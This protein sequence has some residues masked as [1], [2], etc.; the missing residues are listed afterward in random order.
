MRALIYTL[1][2][3]GM[4]IGEALS[5]KVGDVNLKE[6]PASIAIK[7]EYSKTRAGRVAYISDEAKE[8]LEEIID[9]N[10]P[11]DRLVFDYSGDLWQKG[12]GSDQNVHRSRRASRAERKD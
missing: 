6:E 3:S 12:K 8:A 7:A 9:S 5:I 2:S 1:L 11:K 4:R 10:T